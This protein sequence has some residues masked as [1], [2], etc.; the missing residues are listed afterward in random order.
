M[1][2][3]KLIKRKRLIKKFLKSIPEVKQLRNP[4][5]LTITNN[6]GDYY[7]S[8]FVMHTN[9]SH[10]ITLRLPT[11][12][13]RIKKGYNS[14]YPGRFERLSFVLNNRRLAIRFIILHELG[15]CILQENY[16][17]SESGADDYAINKLRELGL[18]KDK[19]KTEDWSC[20]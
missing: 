8:N 7:R 17:N 6:D 10:L 19:R 18:L 2:N 13:K 16:G 11:I 4:V 12:D 14:Y 20:D 1:N 5:K 9:Y 3:K 15:H